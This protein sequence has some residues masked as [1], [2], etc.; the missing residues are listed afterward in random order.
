MQG[1]LS[2]PFISREKKKA[3][4]SQ[5]IP[6][7]HGNPPFPPLAHNSC[8][9]RLFKTTQ[10]KQPIAHPGLTASALNAPATS[11][12][13]SNAV[14]GEGRSKH[15]TLPCPL[16]LRVASHST[17]PNRTVWR[18]GGME[19]VAMPWEQETWGSAE[20]PRQGEAFVCQGFLGRTF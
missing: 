1:G 15:V 11:S 17:S 10:Q 9:Q 8:S 20:R 2:N 6:L 7:C 13:C 3:I 16:P 18:R 5:Q 14:T 12:L 19:R 4:H